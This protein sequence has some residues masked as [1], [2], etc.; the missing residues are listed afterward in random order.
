M[1]FLLALAFVLII[2][3]GTTQVFLWIEVKSLQK[4][5][6]QVQY[7]N[8]GEQDFQKMTDELKTK[9]TETPYDNIT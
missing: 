5:T 1:I 4:S 6:H 9:L 8:I 7:V 2:L 3:I